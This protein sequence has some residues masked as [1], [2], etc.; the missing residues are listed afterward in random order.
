MSKRKLTEKEEE[1]IEDIIE[2]FDW[3]RVYKTMEALNW[4]W[5][6]TVGTPSI[7]RLVTMAKSHLES[8]CIKN[9]TGVGSGGFEVTREN[10]EDVTTYLELRFVVSS[11][12][13]YEDEI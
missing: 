11:W 5:Y 8:A 13:T 1:Y 12:D 10:T 2:N 4:S 9:L 3:A 6:D 7:G